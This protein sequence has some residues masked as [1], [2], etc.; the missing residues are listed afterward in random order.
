M[1]HFGCIVNGE[2]TSYGRLQDE[3]AKELLLK[4]QIY[5]YAN[6]FDRTVD[7]RLFIGPVE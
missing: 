1:N 2:A 5:Q 4:Y 6:M 7:R 3:R